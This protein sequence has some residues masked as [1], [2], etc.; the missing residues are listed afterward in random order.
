M[1]S[2]QKTHFPSREVGTAQTPTASAPLQSKVA[3]SSGN[4]GIAREEGVA[5]GL[6]AGESAAVPCRGG[7]PGLPFSTQ[8]QLAVVY[9][10]TRLKQTPLGMPEEVYETIRRLQSLR[11]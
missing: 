9:Q 7:C 6:S 10:L 8:T 5:E 11:K 3:L 4:V 1:H 2:T